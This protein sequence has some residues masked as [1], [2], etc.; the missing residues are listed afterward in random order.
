MEELQHKLYTHT[1]TTTPDLTLT[2][3][4]TDLAGRDVTSLGTSNTIFMTYHKHKFHT[5]PSP[6]LPWISTHEIASSY[7]STALHWMHSILFRPGPVLVD[8]SHLEYDE[9]D[10]GLT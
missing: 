9:N 1:Q 3:I 5:L 7:G 10:Y 8:T 4:A 6:F 2:N